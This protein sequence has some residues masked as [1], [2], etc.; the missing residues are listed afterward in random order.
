MSISSVILIP[1]VVSCNIKTQKIHKLNS[2]QA[3]ND[4]TRTRWLVGYKHYHSFFIPY[5]LFHFRALLF[6]ASCI[7]KQTSF[8]DVDSVYKLGLLQPHVGLM[9][10]STTNHQRNTKEK[11]NTAYFALRSTQL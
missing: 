4:K 8:L 10:S 11:I 2:Y 9:H 7:P 3:I 6:P 1:V 5:S